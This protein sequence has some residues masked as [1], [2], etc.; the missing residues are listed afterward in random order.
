MGERREAVAEFV[1]GVAI[2]AGGGVGREAQQGGD[3]Q[4]GQILVD[5]EVDD[6]ALF[7]RQC[8]EGGFENA[9]LVVALHG[10]IH[11]FQQGGG[12]VIDGGQPGGGKQAITFVADG[13]A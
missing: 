12:V 11:R 2:A 10:G 3:L 6:F 5:L 8:R 13:D 9:A 7:G 1:Q 4:E